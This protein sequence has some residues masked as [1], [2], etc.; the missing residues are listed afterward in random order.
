MTAAI[1]TI[2]DEIL[3]GQIVNTNA[4]WIGSEL[5]GLGIPVS[6][7]ITV[8]D[9][10]SEMLRTLDRVCAEHSIVIMTGGLGPTHDDITKVTVAEYFGVPLV[11]DDAIL[12]AVASRYVR[13]GI[14]MPPSNVGQALVPVGFEAIMN[15]AGSAPAL[16]RET[17]S[18]LLAVLPGVPHEMKLFME[19]QV[20]SRIVRR[21]GEVKRA[22][23]T[24]LVA[25][26]GESALQ[27]QLEGLDEFLNEGRTLAFLPNLQTLRLR[28]T[29]IGVDA[30]EKLTE[31]ES[32]IRER[33]SKWIYGEGDSSLEKTVGE[34]LTEMNLSVAIAES[35][36][37][38]FIAHTLTNVAGSSAY[39]QGGVVA[40]SNEVKE[41]LLGVRSNTLI[42][43]GAVSEQTACEMA[44]GVRRALHA[45]LGLSTTGI[46]GP[47]GGSVEK[48]VGT[49][50]VGLSTHEKTFAVS[51]HFGKDRFRNKERTLT[52]A[53]NLLRRFLLNMED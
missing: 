3:I 28:L 47:G 18:L 39:M 2:G 15:T 33:A 36:T 10:K 35:C 25:G 4:A 29:T 49:V 16:I 14:P 51:F 22:Q 21:G 8:G 37:G 1:L 12:A 6:K 53:L 30:D 46:L 43:H 40:Y 52:A 26:I 20:L 42:E 45:D 17:E 7:H 23:K 34:L 32:W 9:S 11:Q 50:W 44:E 24:L 41:Q 13:R 48:P 27:Q 38:G 5:T 31:F 19:S